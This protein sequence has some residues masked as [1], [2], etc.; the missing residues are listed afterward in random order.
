MNRLQYCTPKAGMVM[1]VYRYLL[2]VVL[3]GAIAS[4]AD[5]RSGNYRIGP[6]V[7]ATEAPEQFD[8][9]II[10]G[11][12]DSILT[13]VDSISGLSVRPGELILR[14]KV[15]DQS[16]T[17]YRG[18][19]DTTA[20]TLNP[21]LYSFKIPYWARL[22]DMLRYRFYREPSDAIGSDEVVVYFDDERI[23]SR[24]VFPLYYYRN[25][26]WFPLSGGTSRK[27]VGSLAL[28]SNPPDA[29]V[30]VNGIQTGLLTPCTV[31]DLLGGEYSIEVRHSDYQFFRRTIRVIPDST[32]Q[33][34]FELIA[35]V[36]TVFISGNAPYSLL[37]LPEPPSDFPY[38]VD[39]SLRIYNQKIR[40]PAGE[41]RLRWAADAR[42]E[43]LDTI[44]ELPPGKVTYFDY[45]FWRRFGIVRIVP[46]PS[47]VEVCIDGFGCATGE[48]IEELPADHYNFSAYRQ[49]FRRLRSDMHVLP[50]TLTFIPIDLR[51][52]PDADAD[53][54]VDSVDLCPDRYGL[55]NGCPT[56]RLKT[57]FTIMAREIR[58][59][60]ATDSL[61]FG[62]ELAGVVLKTP[63]NRQFR[64]FLSVFSSGL[65]GG[66][67][68]Y[69]G[70]NFLNSFNATFRGFFGMAELGQWTAGLQYRRQDTLYIDSTHFVYYD[71]LFNVEPKLYIPSTAVAL[72]FHYHRSRFDITWAIGYQW[73]DIIIDQL[74]SVPEN[75]LVRVVFDNDWW[76]HLIE[77][78]LDLDQGSVF[79]PSFYTRLKFSFG[80]I[81]RTRWMAINFGLQ[82][83]IFTR[84]Y[85]SEE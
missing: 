69:R 22:E 23:Y 33:A 24:S 61:A 53:G 41:H 45:V 37:L 36:D 79:T 59:F 64:N 7:P 50:D 80:E 2:M 43:S 60:V 40:L 29:D 30:Y 66:V 67:N 21:P 14:K 34:S 27:P 52:V 48:R 63:T 49:G 78:Q 54:F 3:V 65:T 8:T 82:L 57:G 13:P 16:Y 83:K 85:R 42:F 72:G 25:G 77:M 12:I 76:F 68:N 26:I 18:I 4:V 44:I 81:K 55:Y 46:F 20:F 51:Q 1:A 32:V 38:V 5:V 58:E 11:R 10:K 6:I 19:L 74:Y 28:H 35:D 62:I 39:D 9:D 31:D 56:P 84:P 73:E 47:D 75:G 71:S 17:F 15:E 70:I